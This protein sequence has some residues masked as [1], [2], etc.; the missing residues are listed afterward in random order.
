MRRWVL[1]VL[2]FACA[3]GW[4]GLMGIDF[5]R[6]RSAPASDGCS[7]E[8]VYFDKSGFPEVTVYLSI[9]DDNGQL[10]QG[11]SEGDFTVIEDE[12]SVS[13][14]GFIGGGVQPVTA[15]MLIDRSGSMGDDTKMEDA[16]A[17]AL[18]FL[19]RLQDGRDRLGV[20]AFDDDT[21]VLGSL[22]AMDGSVRSSLRSRISDLDP[23]GGTAYY[24]AIYQAIGMLGSVSGRKVALALTDGIDH[25][26]SHSLSG[27][28]QYAQDNNVV[29]YTIG[30]G[31]DVERHLLQQIASD[32]D[33]KYYEEPSGDEL[34]QLY[35]DIAQGLRDEY[36]LTYISPTPRLDGTT[37][38]VETTVNTPAGAVTAV[39]RYAVGGTFTPS[40]NLWPCLGALPL[41]AMLALPSL[42]D[43]LRGQGQMA[44]VELA[45]SP[46]DVS[47]PVSVPPVS[48]RTGTAVMSEEPRPQA[49]A[50]SKEKALGGCRPQT[51]AGHSSPATGRGILAFSRE[52]SAAPSIP[53]A[54]VVC[55]GCGRTLRVGARF[56][57]TCGQPVPL[58]S[59]P[60]LVCVHCGASTRPGARFCR[61]CGQPVAAEP[62]FPRCPHCGA[63]LKR[64]AGF[65][66]NCGQRV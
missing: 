13:I 3:V 59:R 2:L 19:D 38:Q 24:D 30:L 47:P 34:A 39:G 36:S 28:I 48:P 58:G 5:G 37:R 27:V 65:C 41:L 62:A 9:L 22:Q 7:A 42:Y 54:Q 4:A 63:A 49:G 23:R 1:L 14:A 35:A 6:R 55:L 20:I 16:I 33:G 11:L 50:S 26:S 61:T 15:V 21:A 56:C 57:S 12:V 44:E 18:T 8:V 51:P 29:V 60:A 43:R 46:A 32:T 52:P 45:S 10:V 40:L 53:E 25:D 66:A 31:S 64:R 17:A